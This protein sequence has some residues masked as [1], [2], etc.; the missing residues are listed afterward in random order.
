MVDYYRENGPGILSGQ[1][2]HPSNSF[3]IDGYLAL[4]LGQRVPCDRPF[5]PPARSGKSGLATAQNGSPTPAV[6]CM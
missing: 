3:G 4:L 5:T 1:L 2:L 6:R